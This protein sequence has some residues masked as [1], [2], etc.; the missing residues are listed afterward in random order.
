MNGQ[1]VASLVVGFVMLTGVAVYAASSAVDYSDQDGPL[2]PS[3]RL[4]IR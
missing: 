2:C 3:C 1:F 4:I